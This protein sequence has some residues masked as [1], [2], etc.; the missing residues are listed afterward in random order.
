MGGFGKVFKETHSQEGLFYRA[1]FFV[2]LLYIS[3]KA[4][5]S[6]RPRL[7]R[8]VPTRLKLVDIS[9]DTPMCLSTLTNCV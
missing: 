9:S 8:G 7:C 2:C 5:Y 3:T 1:G 4:P 6:M